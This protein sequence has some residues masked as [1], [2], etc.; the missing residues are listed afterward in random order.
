MFTVTL[1]AASRAMLPE[2]LHV[3]RFQHHDTFAAYL[4]V[5]ADAGYSVS[6]TSSHDSHIG[7]VA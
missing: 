4:Q 3:K 6:W 7:G 5:W 2:S 1:P